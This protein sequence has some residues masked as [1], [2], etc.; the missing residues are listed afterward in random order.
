VL[1]AEFPPSLTQNILPKV[2]DKIMAKIK[3][4]KAVSTEAA[5]RSE[6]YKA[7]KAFYD[8]YA[9][10]NPVKYELKKAGFEKILST[11]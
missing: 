1:W 7:R 8:A 5:E 3:E 9:K 11:L 4:T 10:Q 2:T 6:A